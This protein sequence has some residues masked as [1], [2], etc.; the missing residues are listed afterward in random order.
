MYIISPH[1]AHINII[2]LYAFKSEYTCS[3][4]SKPKHTYLVH[5]TEFHLFALNWTNGSN[6]IFLHILCEV[7]LQQ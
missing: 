1:H 2:V 6:I 7:I 3:M 4:Q 5:L